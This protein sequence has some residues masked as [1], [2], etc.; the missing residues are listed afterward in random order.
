M[1]KLD[2]QLED[3]VT[4]ELGEVFRGLGIGRG[5]CDTVGNT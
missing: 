5:H 4:L 3:L 2:L 1:S